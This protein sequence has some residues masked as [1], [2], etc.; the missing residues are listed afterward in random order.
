MSQQLPGEHEPS[1]APES[2]VRPAP[3]PVFNLPGFIVVLAA[4]LLL[5]HAARQW[6]LSPET[7][8]W[9]I[10]VFSFIPARWS[11]QMD[12]FWPMAEYWSPFS[13]SLLHGDWMHVMVNLLWLAAFGSPVATRLG[14]VRTTF[15]ACIASL[16][17]ALAHWLAYQGEVVPMI[18]ASAVVSGFMGA[19]TRFAFTGTRIRGKL[20]VH[21]PA[22]S[23]WA[24][25]TNPGIVI[26]LLV[27]FALNALFGS[28]IVPIAGSAMPIAWQA[29]MG[30]FVAGLLL[31][32]LF[33]R[34]QPA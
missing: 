24:S 25:L 2:A 31:F 32:P 21:G 14:P 6:L 27:W 30:G 12:G 1:P 8:R 33:D 16:G 20:N 26:F 29:H 17:G 19:A 13:Y 10:L 5:I 22:L 23:L 34:R 28:G 9:V 18:G 11:G 3:E 7:D 4:V 15:L